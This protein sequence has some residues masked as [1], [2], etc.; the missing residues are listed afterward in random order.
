MKSRSRTALGV[1]KPLG[2]SREC[3]TYP[4]PIRNGF[5]AVGVLAEHLGGGG[6][7]FGKRINCRLFRVPVVAKIIHQ[8]VGCILADRILCD[9]QVR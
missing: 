6:D 5:R 4:R 1:S 8:R 7:A 9:P 3:R 2:E